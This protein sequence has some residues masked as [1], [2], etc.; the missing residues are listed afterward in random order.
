MK[1]QLSAARRENGPVLEEVALL[2]GQ[3]EQ[4]EIKKQWLDVFNKHFLVSEEDLSVLAASS[5]GLG[6][7]FFAT[8][9]R[10]NVIHGDCQ[11]LLG[12]E[13]HRLGMELMEQCTR[14]LNLGYQKL[15]RWVQ[16]ELKSLNLENPQINS[17]IRRALRGLSERPTLFQGCMDS[18][19]E[20]RERVLADAF[21]A[22]LTGSVDRPEND[23][24]MRPIEFHAHDPLRYVGDMLAWTHSTTVSER[25]A[26]ESLFVSEAEE[27]K[28]GFEV[29]RE[30]EPWSLADSEGFDGQK[31]LEDLVN[32]DVAG[33]ARALRQRI[34]QVLQNHEDPVLLYKI[35]NLINFYHVTFSKLLGPNSSLLET[36]TSLEDSCFRHFRS[37]V[38]E[39]V[40]SVNNDL[41][42]PPA[43]LSIPD[44][45]NESLIQ[46]GDFLKSYDA[47]LVPTESRAAGFQPVLQTAFDP[48]ILA[49]EKMA[50]EAQ[51][52]DGNIFM[53]NC[54]LRALTTLSK[55]DFVQARRSE[56]SP[57]L[58][59]RTASLTDYQHAYFLHT[60]GLHSLLVT[61]APLAEASTPEQLLA[62][63]TRLPGLQPQALSEASQTLDDFL[64]SAL[65]DA[66]ENLR[67]LNSKAVAQEI[68]AEAAE[69]FCEDF[70]YME[71]KILA[72]DEARLAAEG[73]GGREGDDEDGETDGE[74]DDV[75]LLKSSFPRTTGEIRVLLS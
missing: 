39:S 14:Q 55:Y 52:P 28:K 44:F 59:E 21:Y 67:R 4:L 22:A 58:N 6:E 23:P 35:S 40:A 7:D 54:L 34:Q 31:A 69:R 17:V 3:K 16:N 41:T 46:V 20:A 66:M 32:R 30:A 5:E 15:Y 24:M 38:G 13:N 8:L 72:I 70:E 62:K 25:E 51:D 73:S 19:A 11:I 57:A 10:L 47:S 45:L 48:Y 65:T 29:G 18:F 36:L 74:Q 50:K 56:L 49:C 27:F 71:G 75:V 61:L 1:Q 64:P 42:S 26:L 63:T 2:L 43:D 12:G 37:I 60:S 33:V 68:T 53:T 9:K